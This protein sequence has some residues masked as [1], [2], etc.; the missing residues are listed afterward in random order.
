[1][2]HQ[3]FNP[4]RPMGN[5]ASA[6][7]YFYWKGHT[8][9]ERSF[10]RE[11]GK[12]PCPASILDTAL[13]PSGADKTNPPPKKNLVR[14]G[15]QRK[16]HPPLAH[17][18][19]GFADFSFTPEAPMDRNDTVDIVLQTAGLFQAEVGSTCTR[20]CRLEDINREGASATIT[21]GEGGEL[22][23]RIRSIASWNSKKRNCSWKPVSLQKHAS[24][25]R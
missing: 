6:S 22:L 18:D 25:R 13:R 17:Q 8:A 23:E 7:T 3:L 16:T 12:K 20:C 10:R 2:T 14:S 19:F 24:Q 21:A 5:T 4:R 15:R 1:M 9:C 11:L